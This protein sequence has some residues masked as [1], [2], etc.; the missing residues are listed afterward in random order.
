MKTTTFFLILFLSALAA[1]AQFPPP[2]APF[3][4]PPP[5]SPNSPGATAP[6]TPAPAAAA[7][8]SPASAEVPGY[9]YDWPAVDINQVLDK[10]A[11]LVGRTLLRSGNLPSATVTLQM[12]TPMTK[13]E[14]IE[15]LQALL[16]LNNISVINIGDKFAEVV[17]TDQAGGVGAALNTNSSP[18]DLPELGSYVTRVVQLVSCEAQRGHS[19]A[20]AFGQSQGHHSHRRQRHSGDP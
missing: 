5:L 9:Q 1:W 7:A 4:S 18:N 6:T 13:A 8:A 14:T 17:P 11:D 20:P 12:K 19:G 2:R 16:G 10:Y 15:A 3:P